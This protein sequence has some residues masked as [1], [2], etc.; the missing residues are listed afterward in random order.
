MTRDLALVMDNEITCE[1]LE[2]E[3]KRAAKRS[4]IDLK[5]FDLYSGENLGKGKKQIAISLTF[6]DNTRTLEAQEVD[7]TIK[8]ILDK[9]S[10][11]GIELRQ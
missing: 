1:R 10:P 3:I 7:Q 8:D 11:L 5:V 2:G 4:L 6:G 9:L